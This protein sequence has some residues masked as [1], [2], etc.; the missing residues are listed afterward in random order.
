M[1]SDGVGRSRAALYPL[2]VVAS[3]IVIKGITAALTGS[4]AIVASLVDS[5]L[6]FVASTGNYLAIRQADRPP[7]DDHRWGHGKA[8]SLAGL[9]Q[10]AVVVA[11]AAILLWQSMLRILHPAPISNVGLGVAVM[12]VSL[13]ASAGLTW[14]LQR[15]GR[16]Y[17]SLALS[18]DSLHYLS[19]VLTNSATILALVSFKYLGWAWADAVV[20]FIIAAI[21]VK[22]AVDIGRQAVDQ[23]MDRE[24]PKSVHRRIETLACSASPH[25]FGMHELRTRQSGRTTVLELHLE[26]RADLSFEQAHEVTVQVQN[27][28]EGELGDCIATIHADPFSHPGVPSENIS[29]HGTEQGAP[30]GSPGATR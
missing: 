6:D 24:L 9:G 5:V 26:I 3:L 12:A 16:R 10:A 13:V 2:F 23:L 25:V 8:E 18:A 4:L 15:S 27:A 1:T 17:G 29:P 7:D 30:R 11:S 21:L 28:I 22:S 20:S 19:D 14:H